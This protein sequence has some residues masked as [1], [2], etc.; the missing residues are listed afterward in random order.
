MVSS[1]SAYS[2]AEDIANSGPEDKISTSNRQVG[3]DDSLK[4]SHIPKERSLKHEDA[5]YSGI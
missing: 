2:I 4:R 1:S 3:T 5:C